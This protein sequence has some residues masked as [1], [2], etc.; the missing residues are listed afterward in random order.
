M[1]IMWEAVQSCRLSIY[2]GAYCISGHPSP[3]GSSIIMATKIRPQVSKHFPGR[4]FFSKII[5]AIQGPWRFHMNFRMDFLLL[6][7][8]KK[9]VIG[10][11]LTLQIA[12]GRI[13]I[14]AILS[15]P[16]HE[17]RCLSTYLSHALFEFVTF[18]PNFLFFVSTWFSKI[19]DTGEFPLWFS[20]NEPNQY[21]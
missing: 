10:I 17:H 8:K 6:Q 3:Q 16:I 1:K 4:L 15:L 13:D 7:K 21:P 20:G 9:N 11:S 19:Q 2:C 18:G 12:L 5:L 14:L